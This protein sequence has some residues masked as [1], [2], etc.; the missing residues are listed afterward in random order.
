MG[1]HP[2]PRIHL[3]DLAPHGGLTH[4]PELGER[5]AAEFTGRQASVIGMQRPFREDIPDQAD[6]P[7][8]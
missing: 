5:R 2:G 4:S 7:A 8:D 1:H 6:I 3:A